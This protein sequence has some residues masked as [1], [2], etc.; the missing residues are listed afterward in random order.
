MRAAVFQN[1]RG[2]SEILESKSFNFSSLQLNCD[3]FFLVF[4]LSRVSELTRATP[5]ESRAKITAAPRLQQLRTGKMY[6]I[7]SFIDLLFLLFL[8]FS[9]F[10]FF[11]LLFY[12]SM[13]SQ[14]HHLY[15]PGWV[16]AAAPR[17][18]IERKR[19]G[20]ESKEELHAGCSRPSQGEAARTCHRWDGSSHETCL[21]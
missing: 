21:D 3:F 17:R 8:L 7:S 10:L 9:L 18:A 19:G 13:Y 16:S 15:V 11:A 5:L 14:N 6:H 1:I 20:L 2:N 12:F 4:F